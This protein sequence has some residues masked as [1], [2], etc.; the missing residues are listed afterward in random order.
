M[1]SYVD[2]TLALL[3][4]IEIPLGTAQRLT[5][6][7]LKE[8]MNA[9]LC[10]GRILGRTLLH[11]TKQFGHSNQHALQLVVYLRALGHNI[12]DHHALLRCLAQCLLQHLKILLVDSHRLVRQN[13]NTG[14]YGRLNVTRLLAIV[15]RQHD[16]VTL[17]LLNHLLKEVV[18]RVELLVPRC[19]ALRALVV[20][21]H[22]VEVHLRIIALGSIDVNR[23]VHLIVHIHLHQ[24]SV[25]VTRVERQEFHLALCTVKCAPFGSLS[26]ARHCQS[27]N[28]CHKNCFSHCILDF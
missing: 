2:N 20:N 25:E 1:R 7:I 8:V 13:V 6:H 21:L 12:I 19:G 9:L 17:L 18:A 24:R 22:A 3:L 10:D 27:S 14:I 5:R 16:N 4:Y 15:T 28:G 11:L 26:T 23:R